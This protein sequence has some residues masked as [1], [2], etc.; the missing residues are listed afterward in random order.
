M[1]VP[2]EIRFA[3]AVGI[4]VG[5]FVVAGLGM[6]AQ[7]VFSDHV[8]QVELISSAKK[9]L[10]TKMTDL[11]NKLVL[12]QVAQESVNARMIETRMEC[13]GVK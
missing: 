10:V 12:I 5:L 7:R 2:S 13:R 8:V 3:F 6:F 1:T 11:E 4:I 9:D